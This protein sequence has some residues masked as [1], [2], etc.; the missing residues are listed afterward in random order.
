M[1]D[2]FISPNFLGARFLSAI[3]FYREGKKNRAFRIM[4]TEWKK[5]AE[6]L[7]KRKKQLLMKKTV[8]PRELPLP[9][10]PRN[11]FTQDATQKNEF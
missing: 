3:F 1:L 4:T 6:N 10:C 5:S 8:V 11:G 7:G 2:S 9:I